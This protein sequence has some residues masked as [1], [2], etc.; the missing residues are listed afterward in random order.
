[1]PHSDFVAMNVYN[2][3]TTPKYR[4]EKE[5]NNLKNETLI[6]KAEHSTYLKFILDYYI[7]ESNYVAVDTHLYVC[8]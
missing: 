1:M 5:H 3:H 8:R 7:T 4:S 6:K 2:K